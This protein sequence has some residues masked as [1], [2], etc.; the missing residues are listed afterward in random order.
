MDLLQLRYFIQVSATGN[1]TRAAQE[2]HVAQSAISQSISRLEEQV[3]IRLF[4]R[5]GKS[6][7]L[8]E[9]GRAFLPYAQGCLDT[10][11]DGCRLLD[12][13]QKTAKGHVR[14]GVFAGSILLP[15]LL[16]EFREKCPDISFELVQHGSMAPYDLCLSYALDGTVPENA[17]VLLTE[18]IY[19]AV[20][21]DH[22]LASRTQVDLAE[23]A[24][25]NFISLSENKA[26]RV[27][28]DRICEKAQFRPRIIYESDDPA[29]VRG[30]I[31]AGMG[32]AFVPSVSWHALASKSY[33]NLHISHPTFQRT[34]IIQW[35]PQRYISN[36]V[37]AFRE[38]VVSF[39]HEVTEKMLSAK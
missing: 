39:F 29:S 9:Y 15:E 25:E 7:H 20:P 10:L 6:I 23:V 14:F 18:E 36:A 3:G 30:L 28:T 1:M 31:N 4:D 8:N 17:E 19:L 33:V 11:A 34:L 21:I 13:M 35:D 2:L 16:K 22:R 24:N 12:D 37:K 26:L 5:K 27:V 32:V 38:H